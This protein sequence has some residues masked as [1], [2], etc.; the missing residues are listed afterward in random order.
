VDIYTIPFLVWNVNRTLHKRVQFT[1]IQTAILALKPFGPQV[2]FLTWTYRTIVSWSTDW[3][4]LM[5]QK[6]LWIVKVHLKVKVSSYIPQHPQDCSKRLC[7][8]VRRVILIRGTCERVGWTKAYEDSFSRI[9]VRCRHYRYRS[10]SRYAV[11]QWA[12][13]HTLCVESQGSIIC[14]CVDHWTSSFTL[15]C[16]NSSTWMNKYVATDSDGYLRTTYLRVS[17]AAW[18]NCSRDGARL[19]RFARE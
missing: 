8:D 3:L 13:H 5:F 17:I 15:S 11:A 4:V 16:L 2:V 1:K 14:Y 12:E 7:C 18:V 6:T 19:N 10:S 9:N